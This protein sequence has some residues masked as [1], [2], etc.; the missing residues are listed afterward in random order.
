MAGAINPFLWFDGKAEEAATF[1]A[2]VFGDA[3]I[4]SIVRYPEG[5]PGP[6]GSVMTVSF[7]LRNQHFT[8]LNGGPQYQFS[9][10]ISFVIE[11]ETQDEVDHFWNRLADGGQ[12]HMCAWLTDK[13]GVTWQVVPNRLIELMQHPDAAAAQRVMQAML[14]MQKIDIAALEAAAAGG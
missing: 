4:T 6:A 9:G 5:A 7:R 2:D 8:A 11:C 12:T 10:A 14:H 13:F 3:E 1:Y